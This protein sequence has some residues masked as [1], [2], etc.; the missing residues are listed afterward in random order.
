[1][2][3]QSHVVGFALMLGLGVLA[4]GTLTVSIGHVVDAQ[5]GNA[6][7]SRVADSMADTVQ[8]TD[9][10]GPADHRLTFAAGQLHTERRTLR[11]LENGTVIQELDV[12]VLVFERGDRRVAGLAGA[13]VRTSG[14]SAWL[15]T[16]PPIVGSETNAVLV[17]GAP[18][19]EADGV[20]V[21]GRRGITAHLQT[22][23]S[24]ARTDLGSGRYAVAIETATPDAFEGYFQ[25]QNA[26]TS[27]R[28]FAGD[29]HQS[30]VATYP[31]IRTGYLVVHDLELEVY[32]G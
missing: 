18:V 6:D 24:H 15:V 26:T 3:A 12:G 16:D 19:V 8:A 27:T 32:D 5:A 11:I 13:V 22:N 10:T 25:R 21:S 23:V 17:V 7:T 9:R 28:T 30:I 20:A 1:M 31:G 29:D 14:Q 4:L 2:R